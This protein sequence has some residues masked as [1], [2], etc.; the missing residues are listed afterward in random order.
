MKLEYNRCGCLYKMKVDPTKSPMLAT[1]FDAIWCG[2]DK[3]GTDECESS[4]SECL[5]C[6]CC[7]GFILAMTCMSPSLSRALALPLKVIASKAQVP[8]RL[9]YVLHADNKCDVDNLANPDNLNYIPGTGKMLVGEDTS[10]HQN[11]LIWM[12]DVKSG[13]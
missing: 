13:K 7:A 9:A 1:T 12:Y 10:A 6:E 5:I 11:N 8:E 2:S 4:F 3:Q